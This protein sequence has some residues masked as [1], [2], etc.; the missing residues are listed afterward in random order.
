MTINF[1]II[2]EKYGFKKRI[3]VDKLKVGDVLV[4]F[5][6]WRGITEKEIEAIKK[7]GKTFVTIKEGV[8]FAPA[9]LIAY[10]YTILTNEAILFNYLIVW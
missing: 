7:S 1:C 4:S 8:R 9:F 6:R 2:V 5:K 10:L 3:R